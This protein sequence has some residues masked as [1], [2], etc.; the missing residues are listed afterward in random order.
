[1]SAISRETRKF[2]DYAYVLDYM[3]HGKMGGTRQEYRT[4]PLVQIVGENYFT[5]LEAIPRSGVMISLQER[6]YIGKE[7]LRD[8]ISH[9]TGRINYDNLTSTAKGELPIVVENIVLK[10]EEQVIRFFNTAP[11]IT[12]RMHSLE[13]IPGIGKKYTRAILE[14]RERK[15]F[16][17]YEDVKNRA[18]IPNPVKLITKRVLEELSEID[19]KHRLF[20][21]AS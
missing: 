6:V 13:L 9:I 3:A 8:K 14:L 11:P 15:L 10:D 19:P 21:R 4:E 2:E 16:D 1:M 7:L 20:T 5:L 12:Q 18:G 17:N